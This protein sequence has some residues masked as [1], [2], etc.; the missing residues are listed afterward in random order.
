MRTELVK[1]TPAMAQAMLGKNV[2]NRNLSERAV[3]LLVEA[4]KAGD[5]QITHQGIAFY[6]DGSLADGQHRLAA[7]IRFGHPVGMMVTRGLPKGVAMTIDSGRRRSLIDG[8]K[9]SGAAPWMEAKHIGLVPIITY[10]RRLTDGE[11]VNFLI[12]MKPH[13]EFA[14]Q[15]FVS[16]R[17]NLTSSIVHAGIAMAHYHKV[18]EVS[19]IRFGEV[20]LNGMMS[21]PSEKVIIF[22]REYFLSNTNGGDVDKH[23]K[24]LKLQ[25]AIQA[26]NDGENLKRLATPKDSIYKADGLF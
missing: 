2:N 16:N 4:M 20:F 17:R 11:K 22:A 8:V 26:Y 6:E 9:I 24:Y 21:D 15:C 10:P 25:R 3:T 13:V 23:E 18:D 7:I 14:T 19:L 1:I 12:T 5:W